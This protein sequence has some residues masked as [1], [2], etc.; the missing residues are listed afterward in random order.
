MGHLII[1][2]IVEPL[3]APSN[4]PEVGVALNDC[5]WKEIRAVSDA[6]LASNYFAVGDTKAVLV[7]GTIGTLSVNATYYVY[8][9]GIDHN[10]SIEGKGIT[11]GTFKTAASGG[12]D[13][14][15]CDSKYGNDM[16]SSGAKYFNAAHWGY[17][18]AG[19]GWRGC[20]MRYDILG[21]TDVAPGGYGSTASRVGYDASA[22]CATNPV[23]N[24]LMAALPTD[25]RAVMKPM[26]IYTDNVGD[27]NNTASYVTQTVDY[28]PLL[29]QLEVL[30]RTSQANSAE[31]NY[32][33]QYAYYSAGNSKIKY[34]HNATGTAA[35]W[36]QRSPSY[37]GS[38][39]CIAYTDGSDATGNVGAVYG[40]APIFR[41]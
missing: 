39:F 10:E 9:I 38:A 19:V 37:Y 31:K 25:L 4:L 32:Q 1:P 18:S 27:G 28:L 11:F 7:K 36:W 20:D 3:T 40:I 30:G 22:T 6:G 2:G 24:T 34:K 29:S 33:A 5:T 15:L 14:A 41:V 35:L 17:V 8:I 23:A 12:V 21:S 16:Y 13:V 26:V